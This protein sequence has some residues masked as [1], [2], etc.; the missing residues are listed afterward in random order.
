[1]GAVTQDLKNDDDASYGAQIQG[2]IFVDEDRDTVELISRY[3]WG[4]SETH[5]DFI[6]PDSQ[7]LSILT[8][9]ANYYIYPRHLKLS[10]DF[11]YA[12]TAIGDN[13]AN[14]TDGWRV[15]E[16][17]GQFVGRAQLQLVI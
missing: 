11:G 4:H 17:N 12:F 16:D 1:M 6:A 13:W 3:E 7:E 10:A 15:T 5:V 2:G 9:G 8:V 14:T